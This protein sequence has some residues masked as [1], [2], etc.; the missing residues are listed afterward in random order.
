MLTTDR[1]LLEL[2]LLEVRG[3]RADLARRRGGRDQAADARLVHALAGRIGGSAFTAAEVVRHGAVDGELQAALEAAGLVD[4]RLVGATL[5][6]LRDRA[7]D[8]YV[9]RSIGREADG[10]I[11]CVRACGDSHTGC[12]PAR[13]IRG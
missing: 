4:G 8:G 9:V 6:R 1:E 12:S 13:P 3:L 5:R 7:I 11:W 10:A 2:V